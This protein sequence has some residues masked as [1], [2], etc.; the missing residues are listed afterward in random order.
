MLLTDMPLDAL[1]C[2]LVEP[3]DWPFVAATCRV[4]REAVWRRRVVWW[5]M[6]VH[7]PFTTDAWAS[8]QAWAIRVLVARWASAVVAF[9]C[10]YNSL[11]KAFRRR[12]IRS[13]SKLRNVS[14]EGCGG[15]VASFGGNVNDLHRVALATIE[16]FSAN[17]RLFRMHADP[18][19]G[20]FDNV[21]YSDHWLRHTLWSMEDFLQ[22]HGGKRLLKQYKITSGVLDSFRWN[23]CQFGND[24]FKPIGTVV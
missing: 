9:L 1:V 20:R 16:T 19:H 4:L 18:F 5:P 8:F 22:A 2:V 24:P 6:N 14:D 15:V 10:R 13:F 3:F 12:A 23:E 17:D 21:I 11:D 7:R